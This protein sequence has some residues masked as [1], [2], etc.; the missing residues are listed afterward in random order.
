MRQANT[1]TGRVYSKGYHCAGGLSA[2]THKS[3][4]D[5]KT[6]CGKGELGFRSCTQTGDTPSAGKA[7]NK[8]RLD[9][10]EQSVV[11]AGTSL[12]SSSQQWLL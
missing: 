9:V 8:K 7:Q 6:R 2:T 12:R 3:E 5:I 10:I 11:A 1:A 4:Q